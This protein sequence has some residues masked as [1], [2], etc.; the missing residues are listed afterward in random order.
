[1]PPILKRQRAS[2]DKDLTGPC[3]NLPGVREQTHN[4]SPM[5]AFMLPM[6]RHLHYRPCS[7]PLSCIPL[8]SIP[9]KHSS[10]TPLR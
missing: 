5:A 1:M 4:R 7:V 2:T 6:P 8:P 10:T 3:R 9:S